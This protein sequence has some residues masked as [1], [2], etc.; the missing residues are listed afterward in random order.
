LIV[1]LTLLIRFAHKKYGIKVSVKVQIGRLARGITEKLEEKHK[2]KQ[3]ILE[4]EK[5]T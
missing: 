4:Y 2:N 1:L 3:K 5:L